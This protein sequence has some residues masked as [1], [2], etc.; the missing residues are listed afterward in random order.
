MRMWAVP[1]SSGDYRLEA[2]AAKLDEC[3]LTVEDPTDKELEELGRFRVS[4]V[5]RKWGWEADNAEGYINMVG[6]TTV[7]IN[8]PITACGPL[9]VVSKMPDRTT[10]TAIA[11]KSGSQVAIVTAEQGGTPKEQEQALV[12]AVKKTVTDKAVTTRRG[13]V[14]C[15]QP[16]DGPLRRASRVL[17]EWCSPTQWKTWVERAYLDCYGG[18]TGR[19]YRVYHRHHPH[20]VFIG[21]PILDLDM[22]ATLQGRE[23]HDLEAF[24][25]CRIHRWD[26][27]VPPAEEVLGAKLVLEHRENWIRNYSGTNGNPFFDLLPNSVGD[28]YK[29]GTWDA[30]FFRNFMEGFCGGLGI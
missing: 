29:D 17:R 24:Q 22:V 16:V 3:V 5:E 18:V 20:A 7:R 11:S 12:K 28:Q 9:L 15:P 14:C 27:T 2:D 10:L 21:Q 8:A 4:C 26:Y 6:N 25:S 13:T 19:K 30:A 23:R 1:S